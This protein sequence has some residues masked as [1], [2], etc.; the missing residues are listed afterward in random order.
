MIDIDQLI[1]LVKEVESE[2]PIKWH[3]SKESLDSARRLVSLGI[4]EMYK[5]MPE[6][7]REYTLLASM[8]KLVL[9]NFILN[10]KLQKND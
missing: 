4:L 2:D 10:L 3:S 7:S 1:E 5:N 9:E 6:E 8:T